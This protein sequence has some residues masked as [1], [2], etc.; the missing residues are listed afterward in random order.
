MFGLFKRAQARAD[1]GALG[2]DVLARQATP[3]SVVEAGCIGVSVGKGGAIVRFATGARLPK[4]G[5]MFCFHPGPYAVRFAPFAAAPEIGLH[6]AFVVDAPDPRVAQQRFDLYLASEVDDSVTLAD[7]RALL[8]STVQRELAQGNLALPPCTSPEEWNAFRAGLNRLLYQRFGITV[9]DCVPVD[10]G[11][12]V[13]YARLLR[14]RAEPPLAATLPPAVRAAPV[15]AA[16]ALALRR[17]FLEL[18]A[19]ASGL[20]QLTLPE[21]QGHFR[22]QQA[23][24]QRLDHV[25]L[26]VDT[27]PDLALAAPGMPLA[28]EAQAVRA[29]ASAEALRALD[30]GWSLLARPGSAAADLLDEADRVVANL[31]LHCATRRAAP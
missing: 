17:L 6:M 23:L 22:V 20:R 26:Q 1:T 5:N 25:A 14:E 2:T 18:P 8:E 24:L 10:L 13:D 30:D 15:R 4:S 27:M 21:G 16:D 3:G 11:D 19:L 28:A 9:D 7:F 29:Q 12:E 31:E